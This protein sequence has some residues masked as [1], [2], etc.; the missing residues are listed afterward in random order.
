MFE[1]DTSNS[2]S[3]I[4]NFSGGA[5]DGSTPLGGLVLDAPG[6]LFGMTS[7]GGTADAGTVFEIGNSTGF[8]LRHSFAGAADGANPVATPILDG[9]GNLY[10]TA[11]AGGLGFGTAFRFSTSTGF[12]V[13][14]SFAGGTDGST[15]TAAPVM[16]SN[17]DLYGT[18]YSGGTS[19]AGTVYR[20]DSLGQFIVLYSF[21]SVV[22]Q[23]PG[24]LV[25]D[26]LAALYGATTNGGASQYGIVY[27]LALNAVI[28]QP[29]DH[30]TL[31]G[32]TVNFTWTP[33]TG[34]T[35]YQL[36]LGSS[37]GAHDLGYV[38]TSSLNATFTSVP[39]DGRD[40]YA[41]LY[42][43][44]NDVWSVQDT[45][46]Y[47]AGS[48]SKAQI[49]SPPKGSMLPGNMVTFTWTAETG[50]VSYQLW[51]GS[52]AGT[53][54]LGVLGTSDLGGTIANLPT[55]GRNI[56]ATLWGYDGG[57]NWSVQDT[58]NYTALQ[59]TSA[60]IT[61]PTKGSTLS[62][63]IVTFTWTAETG[64][65]SYQIWVGYSPGQHDIGYA[66]SSDTS[67]TIAGL[68]RGVPIYV[69]LW[70]YSG[71]SWT[72]QDTASYSGAQAKIIMSLVLDRSGS[73]TSNGGAS[74]LQAAVPL[75]VG[76]FQNGWDDVSL[77]TFASN[78]RIDVSVTTSFV[79]PIDNAVAALTFSGGTFGTG[80][81]SGS[82]LSPTAGP[83]ISLADVQNNSV[84]VPPDLN[85]VKAMVYFTDG[86]M[87]TI[88]D[89]FSCPNQVLLNYGGFDTGTQVD[90]FDP[91]TGTDLGH[92]TSGTGFPYDSAGHIC[93]DSSGHLVTTFF[94]QEHGQPESFLRAN[95]TIEAQYRALYTATQMRQERPVPTYVY[96]IGLGTSIT[97]NSCTE[98]FL[99][100]LANDPAALNYSCPSNPGT[101][102]P[103]LPPGAF[104]AVPNCP[105]ATC[106]EALKMA[107]NYIAAR[108]VP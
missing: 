107:F 81:G 14:H 33:E 58:G 61:S 48:L 108:L 100:T 68:P 37:A 11:S 101:Y 23:N 24:G 12:S 75:F 35:S 63:S 40:I 15:P 89:S 76:Y 31:S 18:T 69:T 13:L 57:G 67:V 93:K 27:K 20:I 39:T 28:T 80:A 29:A 22:G 34:A 104:L 44:A 56:Y 98:A 105:G 42:G 94:S 30:S 6:N 87:N 7:M 84:V 49:T 91:G 59:L 54:D 60:Q 32:S 65:T 90:F 73:M 70:G 10:G 19:D 41:T 3:V 66:G 62:S 45:G 77:V 78:A 1:I 16:D 86:L 74:A 71:G 96:V 53:Y 88:Q 82:I 50:A 103:N 2:F 72:V 85:V 36:W 25:M 26:P 97:S 95:V 52:S 102:N 46:M 99:A 9:S 21:T 38:G 79:S 92:Y 4:H 55:D 51:L 83:P 43:Y 47:S 5:N 8:S 64:A 106:T 17:G